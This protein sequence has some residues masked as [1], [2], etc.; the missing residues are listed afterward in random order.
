M[1]LV[2]P[3]IGMGAGSRDK[4]LKA[5]RDAAATHLGLDHGGV[6]SKESTTGVKR[7]TCYH[8]PTRVSQSAAGMQA[9]SEGV[10]LEMGSRGGTFP[11]GTH[12]IRSLIA[13]FAIGQFGD[14]AESWEEFAPFTVATDE[15]CR[16]CRPSGDL[17]PGT[18]NRAAAS[19]RNQPCRRPWHRSGAY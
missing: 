8:Y 5:K 14:T 15:T 6:E 19:G 7:N 16:H 2:F 4:A 18:G 10:L 11:T 13:D 3:D 12:R 9:I 17:D 1:L